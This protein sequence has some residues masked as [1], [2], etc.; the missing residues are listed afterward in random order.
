VAVSFCSETIHWRGSVRPSF[1][2][3]GSRLVTRSISAGRICLWLYLAL[4][5]LAFAGTEAIR[6]NVKATPSS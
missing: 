3:D 4:D 1:G 6:E 2:R 5:K